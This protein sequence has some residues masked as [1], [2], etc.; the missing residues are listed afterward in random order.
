MSAIIVKWLEFSLIGD[1]RPYFGW[2]RLCTIAGIVPTADEVVTF[3]RVVLKPPKSRVALG[4]NP[5]PLIEKI[6]PLYEA[7][8]EGSEG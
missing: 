1:V 4:L 7:S 5:E 2:V 6:P 3:D 8:K